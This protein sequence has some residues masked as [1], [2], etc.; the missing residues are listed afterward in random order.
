MS[1]SN[2]EVHVDIGY[3]ESLL[4]YS[5]QDG[6]LLVEALTHGSYRRPEIPGC[7]QRL[8]FLGDAVLDYL[9]TVHLYHK[10]PGVSPELLTDLRSASVNNDCYA[11]SAVKAGLH[12]NILHL[13][14][15]L[16]RHISDE[17]QSVETFGW[18]S[19]TTLPK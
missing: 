10:Y 12:K 9:I 7:Y 8:E 11:L 13:L 17:L 6:S 1:V 5:F 4:K 16:H 3:L 14:P 19:E 18:E 15:D 2:P